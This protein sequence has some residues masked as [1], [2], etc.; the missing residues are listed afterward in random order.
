MAAAAL[1]STIVLGTTGRQA[2]LALASPLRHA[3]RRQTRR[4]PLQRG[5][6]YLR[7][8]TTSTHTARQSVALDVALQRPRAW[9]VVLL[10]STHLQQRAQA[11]Q[12]L[13]ACL[14]TTAAQECWVLVLPAQLLS[15]TMI[16][17]TT[18]AWLHPL[19]TNML[20]TYGLR[21]MRCTMTCTA[22]PLNTHGMYT[23]SASCPSCC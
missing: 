7:S 12:M 14:G 15:F 9:H 8:G 23:P 1:A 4:Q 18:V 21:S 10:D 3:P 16:D 2:M 19:L 5:R 13:H 22:T 11:P 20:L 6:S 17:S